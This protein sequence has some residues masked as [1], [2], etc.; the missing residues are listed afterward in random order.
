MNYL[1]ALEGWQLKCLPH[2]PCHL[3]LLSEHLD[4][5]GPILLIMRLRL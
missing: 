1:N 5:Q 3:H 4:L 2:P